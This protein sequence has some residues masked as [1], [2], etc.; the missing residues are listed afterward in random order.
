MKYKIINQH[1]EAEFK[2]KG[3][4]LCSLKS[5]NN[6]TE[7]IWQAGDVWP[8]HAP[9]LFPIVGSLKDHQYRLNGREFNLRHHGFARDMD[10]DVLHQSEH[11][12]AFIIAESEETL[13]DF[14]FEFRFIV[15]Y[16][17][18]EN[19]L[20]QSFRVINRSPNKMPFSFGAHP[21]FNANPIQNYALKF[22]GEEDQPFTME[23]PYISNNNK[24]VVQN[25]VWKLDENSFDGDAL[26]FK[27]LKSLGIE[28]V[29]TENN[30]KV[31]SVHYKGWPYLGIWA[32]PAAPYVCIEPWFG[33]AD[34]LGHDG[35]I[36]SK[37][38]IQWLEANKE[39]EAEFEI[40]INDL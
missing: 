14:P 3:A 2:R 10:F 5:I 20:I 6:G 8:R 24:E 33:L 28:L 26:I 30:K 13:R 22:I 1:L 21:A 19:K 11:S 7:Y 40:E 29:N 31:L 18:K 35:N 37:E 17:L 15:T 23:T 39:F 27:Q 9:I 36:E 4:E 25:G 12:I 32:K 34:V 38:G 16:S